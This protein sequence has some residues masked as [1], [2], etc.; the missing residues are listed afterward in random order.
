MN[1]M[2]RNMEEIKTEIVEEK[3]VEEVEITTLTTAIGQK[4]LT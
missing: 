2:V 4:V 1:K 3:G